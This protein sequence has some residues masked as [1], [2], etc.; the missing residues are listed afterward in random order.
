[1]AHNT[2]EEEERKQI[3]GAGHT[4]ILE[5]PWRQTRMHV[6][7]RPVRPS[8]PQTSQ[9][10]QGRGR[11]WATSSAPCGVHRCM[12][13]HVCVCTPHVW[14][15]GG[16]SLL[17]CV[18]V[19]LWRFLC[20]HLCVCVSLYVVLWCCA[21]SVFSSRIILLWNVCA[22][23]GTLVCNILWLWCFPGVPLACMHPGQ[24]TNLT[25]GSPKICQGVVG[26]QSSGGSCASLS[27][28]GD[29]DAHV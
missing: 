10:M 21:L 3:S 5:P 29:K 14:N 11:H 26:G 9:A 8:Q 28:H 24:V 22:T 2:G 18:C 25:P 7:V 19:V 17:V 15:L 6:C 16:V 20:A 27:R 23:R 4:R 1:M 12:R 13:A